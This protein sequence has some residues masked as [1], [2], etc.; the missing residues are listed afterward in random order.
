MQQQPAAFSMHY[1]FKLRED[2]GI[3][4]LV[5]RLMQPAASASAADAGASS[6][7][8]ACAGAGSG[9]GV[10][11]VAAARRSGGSNSRCC[12]WMVDGMDDSN[13]VCSSGARSGRDWSI[14]G[15]LNALLRRYSVAF[16]APLKLF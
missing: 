4:E 16:K 13:R 9:A 14:P 3:L 2:V 7:A 5:K 8:G 1:C 6:G 10:S 15:S 11:G 12:S